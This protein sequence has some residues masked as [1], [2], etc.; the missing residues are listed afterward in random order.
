MVEE[1][2]IVAIF[3]GILK[4][5]KAYR[6]AYEILSNNK[7][8]MNEDISLEEIVKKYEQIKGLVSIVGKVLG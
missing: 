7:K 8:E 5:L 4:G 2:E 6:E 1:S 3:Y